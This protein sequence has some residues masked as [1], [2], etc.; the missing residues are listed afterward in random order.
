MKD[1][2]SVLMESVPPGLDYMEIAMALKQLVDV[3]QVHDLHVWNLSLGK[4]A[5]SV[6]LLVQS[7]TM[8]S[9]GQ[10]CSE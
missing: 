6:H 3:A 1:I 2:L 5:L 10:V 7:T 4:P 9:D 8:G